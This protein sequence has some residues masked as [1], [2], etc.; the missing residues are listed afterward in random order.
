MSDDLWCGVTWSICDDHDMSEPGLYCL[1]DWTLPATSN[2][3]VFEYLLGLSLSCT[4]DMPT[5][6]MTLSVMTTSDVCDI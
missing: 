4:R 1:V 3:N 6:H 5:Q 2:K